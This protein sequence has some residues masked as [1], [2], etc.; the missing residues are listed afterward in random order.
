MSFMYCKVF[1]ILCNSG[2]GKKISPPRFEYSSGSAILP[3][4]VD[5]QTDSDINDC[6]FNY[7]A[8]KNI[9]KEICDPL[10]VEC[11]VPTHSKCM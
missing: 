3:L 4:D 9:G 7:E 2:D 8:L 5:C 11:E 6:E 1:K 10:W